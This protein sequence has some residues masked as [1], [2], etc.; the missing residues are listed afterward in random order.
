VAGFRAERSG[1]SVGGRRPA[2]GVA[3]GAGS[4]PAA[5]WSGGRSALAARWN[6]PAS[7]VFRANWANQ[8]GDSVV[9]TS[10]EP[11]FDLVTTAR[12]T[13][14]IA[15]VTVVFYNGSGT[16]ISSTT[17]N[18]GQTLTGGQRYAENISDN[19]DPPAAKRRTVPRA[20]RSSKWT[21]TDGSS[22]KI[23]RCCWQPSFRASPKLESPPS[24]ARAKRSWASGSLA[25]KEFIA[26]PL[27]HLE[28]SGQGSGP[29]A[30]IG[31]R[32]RQP[33][34]PHCERYERRR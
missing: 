14:N 25:V 6:V 13:V 9:G 5:A 23:Y 26:S 17:E 32:Q 31:R 1:D 4:S 18:V 3:A 27:P 24:R 21:R 2:R 34:A 15:G 16:E 10:I 33:D 28:P 12:R 30:R 8:N 11:T 19:G 7:M 22:D 20:A 29:A